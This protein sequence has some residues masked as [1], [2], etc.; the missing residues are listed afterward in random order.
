MGSYLLMPS[1]KNLLPTL[2]KRVRARDGQFVPIS[3]MVMFSIVVFMAAVVNIYRISQAKL[4]IQNMSDAIALNLASQQAQLMNIMADRNEWLNHMTG[5]A[6]GPL[7]PGPWDPRF[8]GISFIENDDPDHTKIVPNGKYAF[9]SGIGA[10]GYARLVKGI[11]DAQRVF[12]DS[13]NAFFGARSNSPTS[14]ITGGTDSLFDTLALDIH[15]MRTDPT[16]QIVAWN[17]SPRENQAR[18]ELDQLAAQNQQP[19]QG[20][21]AKLKSL[22]EPMEFI[23][24]D[25]KI[26]YLKS[27]DPY[28]GAP[29][30]NFDDPIA[31]TLGK[32][33]STAF[34]NSPPDPD[35]DSDLKVGWMKPDPNMPKIK[36]QTAGQ[37]DPYRI[38][39]GVL[40]GKN[41]TL[42]GVGTFKISALSKAYIV[43]G[44][45][46]MGEKNSLPGSGSTQQYPAFKPTYWV[47]LAK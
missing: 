36:V 16:L 22:M 45:G 23:P 41:I 6:Y 2:L 21:G 39:V 40:V 24:Q 31:T 37:G 9:N 15:E 42:Y 18:N 38:G 5:G 17:N 33:L 27:F 44:S 25:V 11:N 12:Q 43:P 19:H 1:H 28:I 29:T 35:A 10:K 34:E 30:P 20:Q 26:K 13:Y 47:K 46:L 7:P 4:R 14:A 8:P 32:V 3:M